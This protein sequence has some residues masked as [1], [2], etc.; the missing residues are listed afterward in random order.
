MEPGGPTG[1]EPRVRGT[2]VASRRL[3]IPSVAIT[4]VTGLQVWVGA[5]TLIGSGRLDIR[6]ARAGAARVL[7]PLLG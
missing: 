6:A 3:Y 5:P 4:V 1:R 2:A 7:N